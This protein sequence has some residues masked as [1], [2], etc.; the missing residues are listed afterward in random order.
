MMPA[1]DDSTASSGQRRKGSH[2]GMAPV[3]PSALRSNSDS[4]KAGKERRTD[5][6]SNEI[7]EKQARAEA[8]FTEKLAVRAF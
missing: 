2:L 5:T 7:A 4:R 8:D 3:R 6:A 1:P